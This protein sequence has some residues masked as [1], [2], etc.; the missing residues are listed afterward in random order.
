MDSVF[1]GFTKKENSKSMA[2]SGQGNWGCGVKLE[3]FNGLKFQ[4]S[5]IRQVL[6]V[7]CCL[8][9]ETDSWYSLFY[10]LPRVLF[11]F[12]FEEQFNRK[13]NSKLVFFLSTL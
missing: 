3:A 2:T 12:T 7:Q 1:G 9:G 4:T 8:C 10:H 13:Q 5:Y 6:P 11:S